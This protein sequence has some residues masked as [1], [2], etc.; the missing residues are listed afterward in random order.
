MKFKVFLLLLLIVLQFAILF[1]LWWVTIG[2]SEKVEN[3]LELTYIIKNNR[4]VSLE[5]PRLIIISGSNSLFGINSEVL[6]EKTGFNIVNLGSH[7]GISLEFHVHNVVKH[8]KRGDVVLMPL[9]YEYYFRSSLS[10]SFEAQNY[11]SWGSEFLKDLNY[12]DKV[13]FFFKTKPEI[14]LKKFFYNYQKIDVVGFLSKRKLDTSVYKSWKG[15]NSASIN[16][17]G[18]ILSD[19]GPTSGFL[20]YKKNGI[21]Y[22]SKYSLSD[23]K[24]DSIVEAKKIIEKSGAVLYLT[25]P[26]SVSNSLF[27][28]D[29]Q[30]NT[31][32]VNSFETILIEKGL[33]FICDVHDSHMHIDYFFDTHYH[34]NRLG[35]DI[36]SN[37]LA[38]CL[39]NVLNKL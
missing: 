16:N 17:F 30:E 10:S 26:V 13:L 32:L 20:D 14:Y 29:S 1:F 23:I 25:H 39:N 27:D 28:L 12:I 11:H 35:A 6:H 34:L 31:E 3:E 8:L 21:P 4:L 22:L 19:V 15:Y 24:I 18:D 36:R 9:E 2:R 33:N 7:A 38:G 5:S 37:K